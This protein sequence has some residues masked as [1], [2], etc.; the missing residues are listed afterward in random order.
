MCPLSGENGVMTCRKRRGGGGG[1]L[2]M[3]P[4]TDQ[5]GEMFGWGAHDL[6]TSNDTLEQRVPVWGKER[7]SGR[8]GE[9]KRQ[10]DK[11]GWVCL[12]A[13]VFSS[14]IQS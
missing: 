8:N 9:G 4:L 14:L 5:R 3:G 12:D 6:H 11:C 10:K 7:G 13:G 2:Q 1:G